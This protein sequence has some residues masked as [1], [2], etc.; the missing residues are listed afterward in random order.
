[1]FDFRGAS[2]K[3]KLTR[4]MMVTSS[5]ALL[6]AAAFFAI[7]DAQTSQMRMERDLSTLSTI[8][9]SNSIAA[10]AFGNEQDAKS[11]LSALAAKP[12]VVAAAIYKRD[13]DLL[14]SYQRPGRR[15][16]PIPR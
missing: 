1:M 3:R 15:V 12:H 13:G 11:T 4:A 10:L 5:V 7:Y 16:P 2:I 9:G 6:V 14:A 8:I